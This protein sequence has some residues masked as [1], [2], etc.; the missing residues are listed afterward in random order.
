MTF[1][2][3]K[4]EDRTMANTRKVTLPNGTT[5]LLRCH[6]SQCYRLT[7][8]SDTFA[9]IKLNRESTVQGLIDGTT[10][11]GWLVEIRMA[12]TGDLIRYAGVWRTLRD[13]TEEAASFIGRL[14]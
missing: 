4:R 10:G 5:Y 13:A 1:E 2:T 9:Q 14:N 3:H 8:A 7:L 11:T 6:Y 12:N